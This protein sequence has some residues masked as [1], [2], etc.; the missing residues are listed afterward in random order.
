MRSTRRFEQ[1]CTPDC[2]HRRLT[3]A[4]LWEEQSHRL[5]T[6]MLGAK[7]LTEVELEEAKQARQ[8]LLQLTTATPRPP[9]IR[10]EAAEPQRKETS[11]TTTSAS[12]H[13]QTSLL[14]DA[15]SAVNP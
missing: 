9:H 11:K 2:K 15:P 4:D 8:R 14:P 6:T 7:L 3:M 10:A 13:Q 1:T 12:S 5:I